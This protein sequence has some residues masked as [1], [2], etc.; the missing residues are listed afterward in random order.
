MERKGEEMRAP[1]TEAFTL[2]Q[3]VHD[4]RGSTDC[5]RAGFHLKKHHNSWMA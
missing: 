2:P 1:A 5:I 3:D 4:I